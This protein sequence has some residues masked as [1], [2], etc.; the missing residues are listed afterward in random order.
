[1]PTNLR[2]SRVVVGV[3]IFCIAL[4]FLGTGWIPVQVIQYPRYSRAERPKIDFLAFIF[5]PTLV[6]RLKTSSSLSRWSC[7]CDVDNIN[8]LLMYARTNSRPSISV[9]IFSWNMSGLFDSPIGSLLYSY[10]PHGS[11]IVHSFLL[12]GESSM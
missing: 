2:T 5:S 10:L 8:R 9:D 1:M 4:T 12:S 7:Q 6:S 3:A 11:T